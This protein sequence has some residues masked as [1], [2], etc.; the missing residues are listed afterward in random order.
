MP[1]A[2]FRR[3]ECPCGRAVML[4]LGGIDPIE[5]SCGLE[6][7]PHIGEMLPVCE[8]FEVPGLTRTGSRRS[9]SPA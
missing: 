2:V 9:V 5:C 1:S 4:T 3:V 7:H 6:Y 8:G